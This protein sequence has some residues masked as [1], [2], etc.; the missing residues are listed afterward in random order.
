[1]E[2]VAVIIIVLSLSFFGIEVFRRLSLT[3]GW[4]DVPNERSQHTRPVPRGGGIVI[5]AVCLASY[6][7]VANYTGG[8]I[9]WGYV[10]GA[11]LVAAVSW[12]DDLRSLGYVVRI[13]THV[14]V[15]I[16]MV[17][18]NGYWS[19]VGIPGYEPIY[20]GQLGAFVTV[21]WIVWAINAYNFMDGIDGLAGVQAVVAA[22]A[23]AV[24]GW[25]DGVEDVT[26]Y[27]AALASA[28]AGFLVHNWTPARIFMGDAGSAFLGFTF[29]AL[30][31]LYTAGSPE[32]PGVPIL[33]VFFLWTFMFDSGLNRLRRALRGI[34]FW[35]PNREHYYQKLVDSGSSVAV[36]A[37]IYGVLS[38][39]VAALAIFSF[40]RGG[41]AAVVCIVIILGATLAFALMVELRTRGQAKRFA[42]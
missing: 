13:S 24:L 32:K 27:G 15:A 26:F 29:A 14:A 39:L 35:E 31:L 25:L 22:I 23:W 6:V 17:A 42:N 37:A 16:L 33:A 28:S 1:L 20:L 7:L 4:F 11:A 2:I 21:V 9:S 40:R 18:A 5:A 8:R 36:V 30:P 34:R 12:F 19:V 41:V 3:R 38:A 10:A